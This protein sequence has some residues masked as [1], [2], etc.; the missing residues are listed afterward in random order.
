[1]YPYS[2]NSNKICLLIISFL[3]TLTVRHRHLS[4][5]FPTTR[6]A[7]IAYQ[8]LRVDKEPSRGGLTKKLTL[9]D[10]LLEV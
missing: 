8:V 2:I 4:I 3:Q 6:T 7:E 5:P 1:M 10:N 9:N